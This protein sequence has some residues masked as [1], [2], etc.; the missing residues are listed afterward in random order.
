MLRKHL[1]VKL[2]KRQ[3]YEISLHLY[4]DSRLADP[5]LLAGD[6]SSHPILMVPVPQQ[7][8]LVC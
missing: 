3:G 6:V 8:E 4:F 5:D 2:S 7:T 1:T